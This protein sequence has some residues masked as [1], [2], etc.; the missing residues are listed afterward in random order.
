MA[1]VS[2]NIPQLA[3]QQATFRVSSDYM[4]KHNLKRENV[5]ERT[6]LGQIVPL[7]KNIR[8]FTTSAFEKGLGFTIAAGGLGFS[9]KEIGKIL[10]DI[11][12]EEL[13][14]ARAL[15]ADYAQDDL[16]IPI[17]EMRSPE[18]GGGFPALNGNYILPWS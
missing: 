9:I 4:E 10:F 6:P 11:D 13:D 12:E 1:R 16:I 15:S 7:S 2:W 8:P 17:G 18:E 3:M 14:A 5:L